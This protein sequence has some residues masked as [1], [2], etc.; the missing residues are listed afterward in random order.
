MKHGALFFLG[1]G[2]LSLVLAATSGLTGCQTDTTGTGATGTTTVGG[3]G[4]GGGTTTT[5][6]SNTNSTG[7]TSNTGGTGNTTTTTAATE[8]TIQQITDPG[9]TGHVGKD[10]PVKVK[11]VVAMTR[12]F[13]VSKSNATGSCLWGVFVSAPGL[14]E[15]AAN[16]G[17]LAVSYGTPAEFTDAGAGPFCPTIEKGDPAGDAFPDDV[18]PGDIVD[19]IGKTT[20]FIPSSCGTKPG[21]STIAQPQIGFID[22]GNVTR[23]GSGAVPTPH[24][25]TQAELDT[26]AKQTDADFYTKWSGVKIRVKNQTPVL[27]TPMGGTMPGIV[28]DFGKITLAGSNAQVGDKIYYQGLLNSLMDPCHMTPAYANTATVFTQIDGLVY[29]NFCT[30]DIEPSNRCVDLQPPSDNC[31]GNLCP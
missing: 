7:T 6:G 31:M 30:W 4:G 29:L 20:S 28:G 10:V 1:T 5:T 11:G 14:T 21:E 19:I 13:L 8:V 9:A 25:L 17:I 24:E 27:V 15:T 22:P 16:T 18:K 23:T 12:K 26:L 3:A 2:T